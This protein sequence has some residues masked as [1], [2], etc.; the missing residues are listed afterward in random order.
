MRGITIQP[1]PSAELGIHKNMTIH[2]RQE[3]ILP[4]DGRKDMLKTRRR[5]ENKPVVSRSF[6]FLRT[7]MGDEIQRTSEMRIR[8]PSLYHSGGVGA[9]AAEDFCQGQNG[10]RDGYS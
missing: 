1:R 6:S 4:R 7:A 2:M 8:L 9:D 5:A 10:S 3:R